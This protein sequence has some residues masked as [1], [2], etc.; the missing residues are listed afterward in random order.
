MIIKDWKKEDRPREKLFSKG[1]LALSDS[2]LLAILI[3]SGNEKESAVEIGKMILSGSE[4]NLEALAKTSLQNL[5]KYKG[6][7]KVKASVIVAAFEL[8]KRSMQSKPDSAQ[9]LNSSNLVFEIM[10][11]L[12]GDLEH[13]EF[14][15]L[16]LNNSNTLIHKW[17]LSKGGITATLVDV[18]LI[19][20]KALEFGATSIIL[21]HNHPSG[22][23][24]PSTA[25]RNL[26]RKVRNGGGILDIQILDHIIITRNG[27]FSF[28]DE[29]EF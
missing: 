6:I 22:N 12:I 26:T 8:G 23:L 4:N 27:F 13:E 1:R 28:A 21:C 16:L 14:W 24:R 15:I 19:Y 7:G 3:G 11:P 10:H 29:G 5:Q 18:R 2:E 25:D 20:K 17:L 9:K